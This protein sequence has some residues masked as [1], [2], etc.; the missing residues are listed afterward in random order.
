[1][2]VQLSAEFNNH[3]THDVRVYL[4]HWFVSHLDVSFRAELGE[5]AVPAETHAPHTAHL[6]L[7]AR[8]D[9]E[10]VRVAKWP[11]GGVAW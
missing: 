2:Y 7:H 10:F 9:P 3:C 11:I 8:M 5:A 4:V 6:H 1:M